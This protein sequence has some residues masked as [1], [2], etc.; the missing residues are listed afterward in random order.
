MKRLNTEIDHDAV[1]REARRLRAR[2]IADLW[3]RLVAQL[4]P[5]PPRLF[6]DEF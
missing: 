6:P 5:L 1:L 4:S 2:A 3:Q